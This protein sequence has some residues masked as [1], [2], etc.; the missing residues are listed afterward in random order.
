MAFSAGSD[1]STIDKV[2]LV[3]GASTI[4][5]SNGRAVSVTG[6]NGDI[7]I[8]IDADA[9]VNETNVDPANSIGIF[10]SAG[11]AGDIGIVNAGTVTANG[12]GILAETASGATAIV[13]SGT[14][15]GPIGIRSLT[16]NTAIENSGTI[17]ATGTDA[18]AIDLG[19]GNH[20]LV[21]KSGSLIVGDIAVG[22][23][24]FEI[25]TQADSTLAGDISGSATLIKTGAAAL[26]LTGANSYT[27]GTTIRGGMLSV[28]RD[29][30]LGMST[31]RLT[32]DG[33]T[34]HTTGSFVTSRDVTLNAGNGVID[35]KDGTTLTLNGAVSGNGGV[36]KKGAGTLRLIQVNSYKG[37]TQVSDGTLIVGAN[38]AL[39]TGPV[40]VDGA[41]AELDF[42]S[43][44]GAGSLQIANDGGTLWFLPNSS[45]D[46]AGIQNEGRIF[47]LDGATAGSA[48]LT[49]RNG[50]SILFDNRATAGKATFDTAGN[51]ASSRSSVTFRG[52]SSAGQ[53]SLVNHAFGSVTFTEN[54]SAGT[55]RFTNNAGGAIYFSD[56]STADG[57]TIDNK[58]GASI[59]LSDRSIPLT[60]GMLEGGGDVFLGGNDLLLGGSGKNSTVSGGFY[61]G[62]H[63]GGGGGSLTKV[64]TGTL[65]LT[66]DST[67]TGPTVVRAGKLT[68]N[69]SLESSVTVASGA[70]LGGAGKIDRLMAQAGATVAP[71]NSIGILS[72]D[73]NVTF[74]V[75][76]VYQV[77]VDAA[78]RSDR[79]ELSGKATL[80]GGT[81]QVLAENGSYRP[82]TDYLILGAN[83]G[84]TGK[85]ERVTSNF[86]FLMPS[87]S[88]DANRV[89]LILERKPEPTKPTP[90]AFNSVSATSNQTQVADA[91]EAL[92]NGNPVF[93]AVIGQSVN[94]AR[95]A[96]NALSGEA[97]ASS[98]A[99][100]YAGAGMVQN[101]LISRL[102]TSPS[103]PSFTLGQGTY[104]AAYAADRPGAPQ[105]EAVPV[106]S[107]DPHRF[108]LWGEGFGSWGRVGG[109]GNAAG[110]EAST[111]GFILGAEAKVDSNYRFG[112]AGGFVSASF[113]VN[114][115][116]SES[117]TGTVFGSI[118]G[119][120]K[121]DALHI[122]LGTVFASHDVDMSR[123]I[124]FP[125]F[126]DRARASY[127]GST[128][129]IF[130]EV[131]YEFDLDRFKAEPFVG[132]SVMRLHTNGFQEEGGP[133]ALTGYS[134]TYDLGTTTLGIRTE[135]RLSVDF[136]L[137]LRGMVGWQH[138]FGDVNPTAL[139][140]FSGGASAFTVSGTPIDN[141]TLV[142][143]AGLDWQINNDAT[144]GVS[145][146]G[147]IGSLAQEH[148]LKGNFIWR[149]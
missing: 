78:G 132:A 102:R 66:G 108:A 68:V 34:L 137:T 91:V 122:R 21:L 144:L 73:G 2:L 76:S 121:W 4:T 52:Q 77:E 113:D 98:V 23:G 7:R 33:G 81:V 63:A 3:K 80:E 104:T 106:R 31:G 47:F 53:G 40:L 27:G 130:G 138:A 90:V 61:D 87:L 101:T 82:S 28:S 85:F 1:T 79:I 135:A 140:A 143:E 96:F 41:T 60:I 32:F 134:R 103:S 44:I 43:G 116:L 142:A 95:Q 6:E 46:S 19:N 22:S 64:G 57:A 16:G 48:R 75:G 39:G 54:S 58:A 97:H 115:R 148:A 133:A 45:A 136:P 93:D 9:Q 89:N 105:L 42:A 74:A 117:T 112:V 13:N 72:V 51:D 128:L 120:A 110:L 139:L 49:T 145:Y 37:G 26:A 92:G 20:T 107:F 86:A 84:V 99:T 36:E 50:G 62:G 147:R 11:S 65:T 131:G 114:G 24:Q 83:G 14:I 5:S 100:A 12:V 70:V 18:K 71:G 59:D 141:N 35:V 125:G 67:Y 126:S 94:G 55:A 29:E 56:V 123:T 88:Y 119:A 111:G 15:N 129:M 10:G 8:T 109:N 118:Y 127:D 17:N 146:F 30:N 124:S 25:D 149:F 69:G 38:N